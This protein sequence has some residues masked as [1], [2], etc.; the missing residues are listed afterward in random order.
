MQGVRTPTLQLSAMQEGDYTYQLTVTDTIG[1]QATA[2]VTVIV[3]PGEFWP[4]GRLFCWLVLWPLGQKRAWVLSYMRVEVGVTHLP[5]PGNFDCPS[6]WCLLHRQKEYFT[7]SFVPLLLA[8][9][10]VF[11]GSQQMVSAILNPFFFFFDPPCSLQDLSSL[12]RDWTQSTSSE[13][14]TDLDH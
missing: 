6:P 10:C 12:T 1:Q 2:Q 7:A 3:Q 9:Y 14:L 8:G 4:C 11:R 5:S 13:I